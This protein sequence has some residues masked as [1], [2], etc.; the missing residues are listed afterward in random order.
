MHLLKCVLIE[1]TGFGFYLAF[2]M[3]SSKKDRQRRKV[4]AWSVAR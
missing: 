3:E 1:K 4:R 2:C